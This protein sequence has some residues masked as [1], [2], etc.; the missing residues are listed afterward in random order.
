MHSTLTQSEP[1]QTADVKLYS[2]V[3]A[4]KAALDVSIEQADEALKLYVY[5]HPTM[6]VLTGGAA[7]IHG[8]DAHLEELAT[9]LKDLQQ[10]LQ[11]LLPLWSELKSRVNG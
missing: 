1:Q 6:T 7:V 9:R 11:R 5:Q 3:S 4:R 10:Q 2:E 8:G